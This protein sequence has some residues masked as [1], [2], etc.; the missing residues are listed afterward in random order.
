VYLEIEA[1]KEGTLQ[2][3]QDAG[4]RPAT[5]RLEI[6]KIMISGVTTKEWYNEFVVR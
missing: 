4:T 6:W 1:A 5:A 2:K 3:S